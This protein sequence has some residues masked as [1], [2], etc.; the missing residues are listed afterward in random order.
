MGTTANSTST[1]HKLASKPIAIDC[2]ET[3]DFD[4]NLIY[5]SGIGLEEN[6]AGML[7]E[8]LSNN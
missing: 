7:S 3:D 4:P 5:F 1:M 2:F 8:F 6:S